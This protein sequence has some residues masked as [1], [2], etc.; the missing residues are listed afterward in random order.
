MDRVERKLEEA[1]QHM[2]PYLNTESAPELFAMCNLCEKWDG[3]AHDFSGCRNM[4]C[5]KCW[6]GLAYLKWETS[7]E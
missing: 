7:Y 1:Y 3:K 4:P 6:L 5:F 2:K